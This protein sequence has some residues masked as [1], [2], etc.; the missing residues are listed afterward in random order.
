MT[1]KKAGWYVD[2]RVDAAIGIVGGTGKIGLEICGVGRGDGFLWVDLTR[3][4]VYSCYISPNV[5]MD[6]FEEFLEELEG[7]MQGIKKDVIIMGDFNAKSPEWGA[8]KEDDRGEVLTTWAAAKG[9][10]CQNTGTAPTWERGGSKSHIDI[11]FTTERLSRQVTDWAVLEQETLSDHKYIRIGLGGM[12]KNSKSEGC[13]I[14]GWVTHRMERE[15]LARVLA[16]ELSHSR[17]GDAKA[18]MASLEKACDAA[19]PR[20]KGNKANRREVYWWSQEISEMRT[21]CIRLRRQAQKMRKRGRDAEEADN[22]YK[23]ARRE[24]KKAICQAKEQQW[25]KVCEDVED[26]IWGQGYKIVMKKIAPNTKVDVDTKLEIVRELFPTHEEMQ[27]REYNEVAEPFTLEELKEAAGRIKPKKAAGPDGIPPEVTKLAAEL[28]PDETLGIMNELLEKGEFPGMWKE[29]RLVLLRKPGKDNNAPS[30]FRPL[31]MLNA[32]G[33]LL[34]H[35][36]AIRIRRDL[37]RDGGLSDRQYGFRKG[38]STVQAIQRVTSTA[39]REIRKTLKTRNLCALV[40]LDV[41][42]AINSVPWHQ[43]MLEL[44]RRH[45][46]PYLCKMVGSYLEDRSLT[47]EEGCTIKITA[48]VP[49][50]SVLGPLLWNILYN[51][52]LELILREGVETIAYADDLAVVARARED[53]TLMEK[54]DDALEE[55]G[56][57]M[58]EKGLELAPEKTEAVLLVGRKRHGRITFH[59]EGQEIS[60]RESVKYLGVIIDKGLTFSRHFMTTV[61]RSTALVTS[62]SRIMPNEGGAGETKRRALSMV[63]DSVVLYAAPVWGKVLEK[64]KHRRKGDSLQRKQALRICRGY[65]TT[66]TEAARVIARVI[67]L[68]L[69][70]EERI[71]TLGKNEAEKRECRIRTITKWQERWRDSDGDVWLHRLLPDIPPWYWRQ[72]G[73]VGSQLTQVMTSHGCFNAYLKRIGK[74]EEEICP[75][76]VGTDNAEHTMFECA[77]WSQLRLDAEEELGQQLTPDNMIQAMIGCEGHW[78]VIS[79]LVCKIIMAKETDEKTRQMV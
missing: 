62:L 46:S 15:V 5:G 78:D 79:K 38:R 51:S 64:Q 53:D 7:S 21:N 17:R 65:R 4:R 44:E 77:K 73:K 72:H 66:S 68:D 2:K 32:E 16:G 75:Y 67:P 30:A 6:C 1:T 12:S 43:I 39:E 18:Y 11:T 3:I 54:V 56:A 10:V 19:M 48:G 71:G 26:D 60:P 61:D 35:L 8:G 22:E 59:L 28:F 37:E 41:R 36:L 63:A 24:L 74:I 13:N 47:V 25:R 31:C 45:V 76:C 33:K 69:M 70:V 23:N 49:Q 42:N 29:A 57:W 34:E 58:R 27:R 14:K 9:L 52:V 20:K 50:G 40:T 55:I